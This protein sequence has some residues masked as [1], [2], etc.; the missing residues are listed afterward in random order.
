MKPV[1]QVKDINGPKK[2][3]NK[4]ARKTKME[5][6][7]IDGFTRKILRC[8]VAMNG[9]ISTLRATTE[10]GKKEEEF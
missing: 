8:M 3:I 7:G 2:T 4:Q 6:D 1:K 5:V 9:Y 10:G